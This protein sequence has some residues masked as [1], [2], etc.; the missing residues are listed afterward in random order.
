M[1]FARQSVIQMYAASAC[2][3]SDLL[4]LHRAA[5]KQEL[6]YGTVEQQ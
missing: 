1:M 4:N 5:E 3:E 6:H 2:Q